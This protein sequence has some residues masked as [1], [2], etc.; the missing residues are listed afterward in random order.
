MQAVIFPFT[1]SKDLQ[2]LLD[3]A[4]RLKI[5]FRIEEIEP[6]HIKESKR[7]QFFKELKDSIE[8]CHAIARGEIE[9]EQTYEAYLEELKTISENENH[10]L[11][12]I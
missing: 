7:E 12:I 3:L 1:E 5:P 8:E 11:Q 9:P 4:K 10:S 6:E 2:I